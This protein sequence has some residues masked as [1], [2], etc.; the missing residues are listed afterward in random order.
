MEIHGPFGGD[1]PHDAAL[2]VLLITSDFCTS[3]D[4]FDASAK[5]T[6]A[7]YALSP[8]DA[9]FCTKSESVVDQGFTAV[10]IVEP[11]AHA[12]LFPDWGD[13]I[14][15]GYVLAQWQHVDDSGPHLG[16]FSRAKIVPLPDPQ[17]FS[18]IGSYMEGLST[19]LDFDSD[20][21]PYLDPAY[22]KMIAEQLVQ[23]EKDV[24]PLTCEQCGS[25]NMVARVWHNTFVET[26]AAWKVNE[27]GHRYLQRTSV[28]HQDCT[29]EGE[30]ACYDCGWSRL[31]QKHE[32]DGNL[33][34]Y[35]S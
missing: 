25:T 10:Q 3:A 32:F 9:G 7:Q 12:Q 33:S 27:D 29:F 16:W 34:H 23:N 21:L 35:N 6:P 26:T 19:P 22:R 18:E 8:G 11:S 17:M 31:A 5:P 20:D 14:R 2:A 13:R 30:I 24:E 15:N 4:E 1:V 28:D